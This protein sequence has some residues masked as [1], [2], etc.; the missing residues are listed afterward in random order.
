VVIDVV[1]TEYVYDWYLYSISYF[2]NIFCMAYSNNS[3]SRFSNRSNSSSNRY[4]NSSRSSFGHRSRFGG[5]GGGGR[6]GRKK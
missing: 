6:Y 3:S 5:T 4:N 1:Y 2:L